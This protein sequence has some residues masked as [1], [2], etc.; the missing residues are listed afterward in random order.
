LANI[1]IG[2]TFTDDATFTDVGNELGTLPA[3]NLQNYQPAKKTRTSDLS[4]VYYVIDR[5]NFK[6][7]N[8]VSMLY[9]NLSETGTWRVRADNNESNLTSSPSYDSGDLSPFTNGE[10]T[11]DTVDSNWENYDLS[12]TP[13]ELADWSFV[14][15]IHWVGDTTFD[16]RYIR[17]DIDDSTNPDG[18]FEA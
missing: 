6:T 13:A 10:D 12:L 9:T 4:N 5:G 8:V 15:L 3:T 16:Y 11:W 2:Y 17:I 7:L 1:A 14:H 18:Y